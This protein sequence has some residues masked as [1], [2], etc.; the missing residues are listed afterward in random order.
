MKIRYLILMVPGLLLMNAAGKSQ[1]FVTPVSS[2]TGEAVLT[3]ADGR[4]I[5]GKLSMAVFGPTGLS[6][7]G[8]RDSATGSRSRFKAG[9]VTRLRV[10]VDGLA[11]LEMLGDKT[12]NLK[13]LANADFDEIT[14]RQYIYYEQIKLPEKDKYVLAQLLNPGFDTRIRVFDKP[15]AKTGETSINGIAISGGEARAYYVVA[16]GVT[17]EVTRSNYGRVAFKQLFA[18]CPAM[19]GEFPDPQFADFAVH[20]M[21]YE[22][23]CR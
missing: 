5:P 16:G 15:I 18:D 20:V 2:I 13:K 22:R 8:I 14:D 4:V 9:E 6:S 23:G 3:A 12:S 11:R 17:T 21:Y 1:G 19:T 7:L 10:K